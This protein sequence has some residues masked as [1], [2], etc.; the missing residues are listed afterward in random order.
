MLTITMGLGI[1]VSIILHAFTG[2]S[3]GGFV[4]SGYVALVLDQPKTLLTVAAIALVIWLLISWLSNWLFLY[5]PRRFGLAILLSLVLSTG[6]EL[7]RPM[8]LP[9]GL[10][11]RSIGYI[12]PGLIANQ[13]DRQGLAQTLVMLA[14]AAPLVRVLVMVFLRW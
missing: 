2:L 12:V 8:L 10:E 6:L 14:I 1:L 9:L 7:F 4:S 3:A 13:I 5:G 11:W